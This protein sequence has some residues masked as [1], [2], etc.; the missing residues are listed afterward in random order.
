MYL[1]V[2]KTI[3]QPRGFK[4]P[5]Q[6]A[7]LYITSKR[8]CLFFI[9]AQQNQF[10][11]FKPSWEFKLL[12]AKVI[13]QYINNMKDIKRIKLKDKLGLSWAKLSSSWD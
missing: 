4:C 13:L 2:E 9:V 8:F 6:T 3:F 1:I 5:K 11:K 7:G 10:P 12:M